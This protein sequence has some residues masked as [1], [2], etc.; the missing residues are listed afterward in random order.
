MAGP[1]DANRIQRRPEP[2][3][4]GGD[5]RRRDVPAIEVPDIEELA[6]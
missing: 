1:T 4:G 2:I 5:R 6:N 3:V